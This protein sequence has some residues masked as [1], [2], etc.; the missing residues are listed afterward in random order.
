[1]PFRRTKRERDQRRPEIDG[2]L[3]HGVTVTDPAG[4]QEM[5]PYTGNSGDVLLGDGTFGASPSAGATVWG[6]I[7][8]DLDDQA[9]LKA[10]LDAK[11]D[12]LVF[13]S[14]LCAFVVNAL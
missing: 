1:M 9:D 11:Q 7:T 2:P 10:A 5:L 12:T 4:R 3:S 14:A 8:G 13:D 6:T